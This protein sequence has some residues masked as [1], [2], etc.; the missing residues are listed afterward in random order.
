[1][2]LPLDS[3]DDSGEYIPKKRK[4]YHKI[5]AIC[6]TEEEHLHRITESEAT[7]M[8]KAYNLPITASQRACCRH[9]VPHENEIFKKH[10]RPPVLR[11][12]TAFHTAPLLRKEAAVRTMTAALPKPYVEMS[13]AM[14]L[15][16]VAKQ[17]RELEQAKARGDALQL[18]L[19][20]LKKTP[21]DAVFQLCEDKLEDGSRHLTGIIVFSYLVHLSLLGLR[22]FA[23]FYQETAPYIE[24]RGWETR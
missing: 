19:T 13:R 6:K 2:R 5:C 15:K 22:D 23:S 18:Q 14:L 21:Y 20:N 12:V 17:D 4:Q 8:S 10:S 11:D 3:D 1:M 16:V 9:W 7:F 24:K